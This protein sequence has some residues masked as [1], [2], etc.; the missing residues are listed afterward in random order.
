M[1]F[2]TIL[3]RVQKFKS[4][5]YRR[6]GHAQELSSVEQHVSA[7]VIMRRRWCLRNSVVRNRSGV[8]AL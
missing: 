1:L 5:V 4:F 8:P 6:F 7:S 3:N 2:Q